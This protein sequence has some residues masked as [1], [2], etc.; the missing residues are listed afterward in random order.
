MS[1]QCVI[2][3]FR[4]QNDT[5]SLAP[6]GKLIIFSFWSMGGC[7]GCP[8][9]KDTVSHFTQNF[10]EPA[11]PS[12]YQN[13][14]TTTNTHLS[15]P[16]FISL[17]RTE[18]RFANFRYQTEGF[19]GIINYTLCSTYQDWLSCLWTQLSITWG[20]IDNLKTESYWKVQFTMFYNWVGFK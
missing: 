10:P 5:N 1:A 17:W 12:N 11:E 16:P 3:Y 9:N 6:P 14:F 8:S 2:V 15:L 18:Q 19:D 7:H 4:K 20:R 13:C